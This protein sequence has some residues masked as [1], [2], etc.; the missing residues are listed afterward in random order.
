MNAHSTLRQAKLPRP[1]LAINGLFH[2]RP[3]AMKS[4]SFCDREFDK[5]AET[6]ASLVKAREKE[7]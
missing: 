6:D 2:S 4:Q 1:C 7:G 5:I 3:D